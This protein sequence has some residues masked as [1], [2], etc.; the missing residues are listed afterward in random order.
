MTTRTI[1]TNGSLPPL[2]LPSGALSPQDQRYDLDP[3]GEQSPIEPVEHKLRVDFMTAGPPDSR[4]QLLDSYSHYQSG[5]GD[6]DPW[7][8]NTNVKPLGLQYAEQT[9]E[10]QWESEQR[11]FDNYD[12]DEVLEEAPAY[13]EHALRECRSKTSPE[14][15]VE[16]E[17][18]KRAKWYNLMP[19]KNLYTVFKN[20]TL[21]DLLF[22][23][24]GSFTTGSYVFDSNGRGSGELSFVG[25]L[26]IP[27]GRDIGAAAA[28]YGVDRAYVRHEREFAGNDTEMPVPSDYGIEL[29][30]PLL[31]GDYPNGSEYLFIPWSSGLVCQGPFK[32]E[33]DYRVAC[34]HEVLAA[35]VLSQRDDVFLPVDEGIDVPARARRFID[36]QIAIS[37]TPER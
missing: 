34:K 21:G 26:V 2:S 35:L 7:K 28:E 11:F 18:E 14:S 20:N 5:P 29:P 37:H 36:P 19:W 12:S 31:V 4:S 30:A 32:Q 33:Y 15:A 24:T 6:P 9:I 22:G 17:R 10:A 27:D 25:V 8:G 23:S 1:S 16:K 3:V 13:L